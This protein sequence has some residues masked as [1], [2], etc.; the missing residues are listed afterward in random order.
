[1]PLADLQK[2]AL[3]LPNGDAFLVVSLEK[4]GK[5]KI[6]QEFYGT[7]ENTTNL[8]EKLTQIFTQRENLG[9][10][11]E[12]SNKV[13]KAVIVKAPRSEKYGNVVKIIDVVKSSG[14]DPIVLQIDDL[15]Q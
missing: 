2:R 10:F 8:L 5:L 14:A 1:M 4:D 7:L 3:I 6:N 15:A 12:N 13:V 9:V 11:E